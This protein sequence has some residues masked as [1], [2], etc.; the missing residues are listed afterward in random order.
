LSSVERWVSRTKPL[1]GCSRYRDRRDV[2]RM[3]SSNGRKTR[4]FGHAGNSCATPIAG[5]EQ[6]PSAVIAGQ[7]D[8]IVKAAFSSHAS[9][10]D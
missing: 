6:A 2:S 4:L 7:T 8:V 5:L 10:R 9:D 1:E 3:F